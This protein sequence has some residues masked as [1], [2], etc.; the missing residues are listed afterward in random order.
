MPENMTLG[1]GAAGDERGVV[2]V[3][4]EVVE[5]RRDD[6]A[7]H[8]QAQVWSVGRRVVRAE[9][10]SGRIAAVGGDEQCAGAGAGAGKF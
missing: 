10:S 1:K 9:R 7:R 8:W 5:E 2:G 3:D 6:V 4:S